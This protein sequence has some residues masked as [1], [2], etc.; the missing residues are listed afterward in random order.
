MRTRRSTANI[1]AT[2]LGLYAYLYVQLLM[3]MFHPPQSFLRIYAT[4][5][6][7]CSS[8]KFF[9]NLHAVIAILV[10]FK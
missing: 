1:A 7:A 9:E 2:Q 8:G 6:E 5:S 10:L 4:G 3:A